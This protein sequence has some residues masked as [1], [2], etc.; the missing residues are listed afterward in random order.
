MTPE[1]QYNKET[2]IFSDVLDAPEEDRPALIVRLCQGDAS[3]RQRIEQLLRAHSHS[4]SIWQETPASL[5]A[6]ALQGEVLA[7]RFQLLHHLGEGGMGEV[8]SA[9]DSH[10]DEQVAIK[11]IRPELA[12]QPSVITRF[13]NEVQLAR[14]IGHPNVCRVF[15]LFEDKQ[16]G[17]SRW[18]LTMELLNGQT[19]SSR[20]RAHGPIKGPA[21]LAI[22][23][24]ILSALAA[25]HRLG[26]VHRD[27]K[28]GN[29]MLVES[30]GELKPVVM[31]F[32]LA[33]RLAPDSPDPTQL[34][35]SVFGTPAYMAPEQAAGQPAT[36]S[37]D[38]FAFALT[39][40]E[41]LTGPKANT[42][43]TD[44]REI[45]RLS[46][47]RMAALLSRCLRPNPAER[48][49]SAVDAWTECSTRT[50]FSN[51]FPATRHTRIIASALFA[52]A[53]LAG[54]WIFAPGGQAPPHE[55]EQWFR[56]GL[57]SLAEGSLIRAQREFGKAVELAPN[58]AAAHVARAETLLELDMTDQARDAMLKAS[59]AA[60]DRSRLSSRH[61]SY[62]QGIH[63]LVLG[64]CGP[65]LQALNKMRDQSAP[66]DLSSSVLI[67]ARA[68]MRCKRSDE[69][70]S[71]LAR[72]AQLDPRNAAVPMMQA[73][74]AARR[75]DY[76]AAENLLA[77]AEDL[78][79]L[80]D[81]REG[82][83]QVLFYRGVFL[84]EQNRLQ[85]ALAVLDEAGKI[86]ATS[87]NPLLPVRVALERG[88][89]LRLQ[90]DMAKAQQQT[91]DAMQLAARHGLDTLALQALF[92]AGNIHLRRYE[93]EEARVHFQRALDIATRFRNPE[94][95]ARA[96][97]SLGSVL[98]RLGQPE[99]ALPSIQAA[100]P[101][102]ER[103]GD[104]RNIANGN[105]LIGQALIVK[106]DFSEAEAV[107][108][109]EWEKARARKD[110][111]RE[112]TVRENLATAQAE[113]GKLTIAL[114]HYAAAAQAHR[115][116]GK[117]RSLFY[118]LANLSDTQSRLGRAQ[119]ASKTLAQAR[120]LAGQ[121]EKKPADLHQ[122]MEIGAAYNSIRSG[123]YRA[124]ATFARRALRL[125]TSPN[126]FREVQ[127]H[128]ALCLALATTRPPQ[129]SHCHSALSLA[130]QAG[131]QSF[132]DAHLLAA[133]AYLL[134]GMPKEADTHAAAVAA[135]LAQSRQPD[136]SAL[137]FS[138]R[139]TAHRQLGATSNADN[140][141]R[142]MSLQL[143]RFRL[144]VSGADFERWRH[145]TDIARYIVH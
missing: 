38:L 61:S 23:D 96:Q 29:V 8:W 79:R 22:L 21:A 116:A 87:P 101:F 80:R 105:L 115:S 99:Q 138:I 128:A 24:Q 69:A 34:S 54:Y 18:F 75:R 71:A 50:S 13:K 66:S 1:E 118:A 56:D 28:P 93:L 32:G 4:A 5:L 133:Q 31:D 84:E 110:V 72:A 41:M 63:H 16:E 88:L 117:Q 107:Y 36:T 104:V 145:R 14:T 86:A 39:A 106:G 6:G 12:A 130:P 114:E 20:L 82:T 30:A 91:A 98:L 43:L 124:A 15:E 136:N 132:R 102:Y 100:L 97:L 52:V 19:L 139:A 94:A 42:G 3:L 111:E 70:Q 25:A 48:F 55:A 89:V 95:T 108:S 135:E 142:Q 141:H 46:S 112:A 65:A 76:P 10:L 59:A 123:D 17:F 67:L 125:T 90:G 122:R 49:P 2:D 131:R 127:I 143:D 44:W 73:L 119:E 85:E 103:A 109:R 120:A 134:A 126:S 47:P 74:L 92:A 37:S 140:Y 11:L 137:A 40:V 9:H 58:F 81:Q 62:L 51:I 78:Y 144:Q 64:D 7:Q 113:L 68:A 77:K 27:F 33:K 83:G 35:Q 57:Q 45:A 129:L 121:L 26:I 60:P 53:L